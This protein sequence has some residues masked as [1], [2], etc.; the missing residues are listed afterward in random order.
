[1][2]RSGVSFL[3]FP[4]SLEGA[5]AMAAAA[6][7]KATAPAKQ[8]TRRIKV[9]ATQTGYYDLKRYRTGNV[10]T[11]NESEFSEKWME[12]ASDRAAESITTGQQ[13]LSRRTHEISEERSGAAAGELDTI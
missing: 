2:T 5:T 9:R 7:Q 1:V 10:F 4:F 3:S 12:R 8:P 6:G 13:E 11:V